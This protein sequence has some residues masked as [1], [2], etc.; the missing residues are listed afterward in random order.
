M[1]PGVQVHAKE[2][3]QE[4]V[5]SG[6][7]LSHRAWRPRRTRT[8]PARET[9]G[10]PACFELG[11][12]PSCGR[13]D[14]KRRASERRPIAL[15]VKRLGSIEVRLRLILVAYRFAVDIRNVWHGTHAYR[16]AL[17]G[18]PFAHSVMNAHPTM[19][20]EDHRRPVRG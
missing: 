1:A 19:S 15:S 11:M 14:Q 10:R 16:W 9:L 13:H 4:G 7:R 20:C 6:S 8:Q 2:V 17:L 12:E 3:A 18:H 5:L